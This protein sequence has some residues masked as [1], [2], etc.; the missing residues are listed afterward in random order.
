[1]WTQ[2]SLA[3]YGIFTGACAKLL[4]TSSSKHTHTHSDIVHPVSAVTARSAMASNREC[5]SIATAAI[6]G[7][8]TAAVVIQCTVTEGNL[9][10]WH[11][12][13]SLTA[14]HPP[15]IHLL[16]PDGR[17]TL[18]ALS[19][20]INSQT[21]NPTATHQDDDGKRNKKCREFTINEDGVVDVTLID[22][23]C[24]SCIHVTTLLW[25]V[26]LMHCRT[27]MNNVTITELILQK[28]EKFNFKRLPLLSIQFISI[29]SNTIRLNN[30]LFANILIDRIVKRRNT[31][32]GHI[33]RLPS[34]VPVHQALS[35]QVHLS[36]G[37]PPD[38]SWKRRPSRPPKRW[39]DQ[40]CADSQRPPPSRCV[41]RRWQTRSSWSDATVLDDYALT[42]TT[43]I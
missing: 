13:T 20:S 38:R 30:R 35:C 29:Q 16:N 18:R 11:H 1:M 28:N 23:A 43:M 36:L 33:A 32:F 25:R 5:L 37:R 8:E 22:V 12:D 14:L 9:M 41:E 4:Y 27:L 10:H 39:L 40:I 17:D 24:A 15:S 34:N 3:E 31:I 2:A 19:P 7:P 6:Y 26:Q 42:K 21:S